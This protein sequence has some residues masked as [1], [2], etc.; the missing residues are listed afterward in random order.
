[1]NPPLSGLEQR[2]HDTEEQLRVAIR[3]QQAAEKQHALAARRFRQLCG[4][5]FAITLGSILF[6][7]RGPVFAQGTDL[8]SRVAALEAKLA[9][10]T[11]PGT[12]ITISGANLHIVDG[13]GS[14]P[15]KNGT[16]NLII[17]Y[18]E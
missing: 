14:T 7:S 8:T 12:E 2:L 6:A 9:F 17:G 3:Q 13:M 4:I 1:M 16:G 11:T 18:A 15:T 10:L 5:A